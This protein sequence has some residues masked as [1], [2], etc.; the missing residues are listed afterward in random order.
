MSFFV[1]WVDSMLIQQTQRHSNRRKIYFISWLK[2]TPFGFRRA[3]NWLSQYG[4]PIIVSEN[5]FSDFI[6]NLDDLQRI[7]YYKH[8]INQMLKGKIE[9]IGFSIISL[10]M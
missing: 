2:V 6:G 3:L 7:Y 8:Y 9:L 5:G 10:S 4:K 1:Y